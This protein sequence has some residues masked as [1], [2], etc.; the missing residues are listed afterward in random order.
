M[1]K[2]ML[3]RFHDIRYVG[4]S[5]E[6]TIP[7]GSSFHAAHQRT[8]G[9][10]DESRATEVVAIRVRADRTCCE[11]RI[12]I[13]AKTEAGHRTGFNY[14]LWSNDLD[15]GRVDLQD[16]SRGK[17]RD[18]EMNSTGRA[19]RIAWFFSNSTSTGSGTA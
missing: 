15:P 5:Y 2:A 6:L 13:E 12:A 17:P 4:Q 3:E 14:R 8:Y 1:P 11:N 16:R 18:Y 19:I 10:S 9:Y 7:E